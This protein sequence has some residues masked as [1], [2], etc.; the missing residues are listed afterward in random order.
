ME[1]ST[2]IL[3]PEFVKIVLILKR[4]AQSEIVV[5]MKPFVNL[6]PKLAN[7]AHRGVSAVR[8]KPAVEISIVIPKQTLAQ[9]AP[10]SM[11][12]VQQKN[13]ATMRQYVIPPLKHAKVAN[14]SAGV[15]FMKIVAK[16]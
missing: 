3:R 5:M 1:I 6:L 4:A 14:L 8:T 16:I 9:I 15:A 10:T 12:A 11:R 7:L 2:V 13:A